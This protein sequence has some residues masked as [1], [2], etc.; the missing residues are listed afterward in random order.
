[1]KHAEINKL[2]PSIFQQTCVEK[3]PL[4]AILKVM[5]TLHEPTER[6][7]ENLTDLFNPRSTF[8]QF[9]YLLAYWVD[10][11]WLI[12]KKQSGITSQ[13]QT[14]Y[15][16]KIGDLGRLREL[17]A[18]A[19]MLAQWRGTTQG[20]LLFLKIATGYD[21]FEIDEQVRDGAGK[22]IGFH[23]RIRI[24]KEAKDSIELVR[25]IVEREKGAYLTYE[26]VVDS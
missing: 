7:L 4:W 2:L 3:T 24:G 12:V 13:R 6:Q 20:L 11:E 17:I 10:M 25:A 21:Q 1:M 19:A 15:D 22:P 14:S 23:I 9:V 8:D 26:L 5:E 16:S 18:N